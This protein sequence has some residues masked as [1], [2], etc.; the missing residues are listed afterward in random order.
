MTEAIAGG[1]ERAS[2]LWLAAV[3]GI[4]AVAPF[5]IVGPGAT[6]RARLLLTVLIFACFAIALD[7]VFGQTDQLFLFLGA[8]AG[9]GAYSV[10]GVT[11]WMG[12]SPWIVLPFAAL[13]A[14]LIG[15]TVSYVASRRRMTIIVIAI[16]TLSLQLVSE[17]VFDSWIS[18][19]GGTTG[20]FFDGLEIPF[21]IGLFDS[22]FDPRVGG[23]IA[24]YYFL[25]FG[26][27]IIVLLYRHMM[28]SKYGLAYRAIRQDEIAAESVGINVI[29]YKVIAGFSAAF[30][31]GAVGPFYAQSEAVVTPSLFTFVRVDVIVLIMLVLGGMRTL[32]GPIIGAAF[33]V[34]LNELLRFAERWTTAIFGFLLIILFLYFREGVIPKGRELWY[35]RGGQA[36]MRHLRTRLPGG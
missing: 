8:L 21:L 4:L 28:R 14:G 22:I 31:V 18:L 30:I 7:I 35:E 25:L 23:R 32:T 13:V 27:V 26:L 11:D 33:V 16:L 5:I 20:I 34:Y 3:F 24:T 6:F 19:T 15:L 12:I 36:L 9:V 17:V 1:H 2:S 29:K 10:A